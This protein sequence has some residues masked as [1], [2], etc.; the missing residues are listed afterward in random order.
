MAQVG[1]FGGTPGPTMTAPAMTVPDRADPFAQPSRDYSALVVGDWLLYPTLFAGASYDTNPTQSSGGAKSSFGGRLVPSLLAETTNGISKTTVYGMADAQLYTNQSSGNSNTVAARAGLIEN[2]QLAPDLIF[3]GQGD[4]TRQR[5]L[6]STFGID[7]S[8]STLNPTG[9]GLAPVNNPLT[10]NQYSGAASLQKNFDRAFVTVGGSV[11]DLQYD[12]SSN[13]AAPSP[14]GVD[15]TETVRGGFWINPMLYGYAEGSVD[16]RNYSTSSLNSNGYRVVGG[17]GSDQIGLFRG[18]VYAGYQAEDYNLGAIGTVGSPVF[19][20]RLYYYPLPELTLSG[21]VDES[22]GVSFLATAPGVP[23][24]ASTRVVT[25]LGQATYAPM[26]EWSAS[27]RFG[28]IHTDY[29]GTPRDDDAWTMGATLNYS[30]WQNFA[31]TLDYQ[32]IQMSSNVPLQGFSR[33]VV[34]VGLTYKY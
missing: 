14:N 12:H 1:A 6:F 29:V 21:S 28:F 26:Q 32:Y 20:G 15:T 16:Q 18:E 34:T 27:G 3:N 23:V 25:S 4:F 7:H 2:Y 24:G 17:L 11:I 8:V 31:L 9:I 30:I 19:G 5:D 33:D 10:Y 22:L 13:A